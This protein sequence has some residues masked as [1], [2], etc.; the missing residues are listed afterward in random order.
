MNNSNSFFDLLK[1]KFLFFNDNNIISAIFTFIT[2]TLLSNNVLLNFINK[3]SI[4]H[5]IWSLIMKENKIYI[6]G[7]RYFINGPFS[8]RHENI[9][10]MSFNA[11]W[12]YVA[13]IL[14]KSRD[15]HS[16][17]E[18]CN[19]SSNYDD[20]GVDISTVSSQEYPTYVV[21]QSYPF[22]LNDTIWCSVNIKNEDI[23]NNNKMTTKIENIQIK[24]FSY[25]DS[26]Y[27]IQEFVK[28]ITNKY[29]TTLQESRYGKTYIYTYEGVKS[30]TQL[31]IWSECEFE[32]QLL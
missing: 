19:Q 13:K 7:K 21:E 29:I 27:Q 11:I 17:R 3:I 8:R 12:Q 14:N 2:I 30:E 25:T 23:E 26:V 5:F 18:C 31:D 10:S 20:Y 28:D 24:L 6:D 4:K 9:F 16:I 1:M 15:I 22:K 32:T